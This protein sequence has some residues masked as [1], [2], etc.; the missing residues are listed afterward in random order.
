MAAARECVV[1]GGC[2][3]LA[4]QCQRK[5]NVKKNNFINKNLPFVLVLKKYFNICS[6]LKEK[7][8]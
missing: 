2:H 6:K 3:H 5:A 7:T 8:Q 4:K 1:T